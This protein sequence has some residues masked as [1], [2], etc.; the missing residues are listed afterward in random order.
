[1]TSSLNQ[2]RNKNGE[3]PEKSGGFSFGAPNMGTTMA[4]AARPAP[5][6]TAT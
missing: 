6:L 2:T 1:M 3:P 4:I 5:S